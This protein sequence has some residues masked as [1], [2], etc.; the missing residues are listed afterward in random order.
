MCASRG[1]ITT[2]FTKIKQ[3]LFAKNI[4]SQK[5]HKALDDDVEDYLKSIIIIIL[6]QADYA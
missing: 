6:S 1:I 4:K 2:L 5:W 3:R